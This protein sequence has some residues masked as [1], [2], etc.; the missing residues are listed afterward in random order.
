MWQLATIVDEIKANR[1]GAIF[2]IDCATESAIPQLAGSGVPLIVINNANFQ[3]LHSCVLADD[4]EGAREG[5]ARL[6]AAGHRRI[7]FAEYERSVLPAIV[8]DRGLG[9]PFDVSIVAPGDVLD[10]SQPFL[11]SIS[12]MRI[13]IELMARMAVEIMMTSILRKGREP[14]VI[15]TKLHF[16]DRGSIRRALP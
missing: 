3:D 15:K 8:R 10:Y 13:D 12:T 7:V 14:V 11:P 16:I 2:T 5:T 6:L 4:V 9:V 1:S